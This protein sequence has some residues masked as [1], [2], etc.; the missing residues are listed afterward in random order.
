M[1]SFSTF[2]PT[3][4]EDGVRNFLWCLS[5]QFIFSNDAGSVKKVSASDISI[6]RFSVDGSL[7]HLAGNADSHSVVQAVAT[8]RKI[9][10]G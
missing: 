8:F 4:M 3:P 7:S 2:A 5:R 1:V 10:R 9:N 6:H